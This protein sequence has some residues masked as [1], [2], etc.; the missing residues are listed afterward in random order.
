MGHFDCTPSFGLVRGVW[1]GE[2]YRVVCGEADGGMRMVRCGGGADAFVADA[3]VVFGFVPDHPDLID[4]AR[5]H[6]AHG[7]LSRVVRRAA[8]PAIYRRGMNFRAAHT[9]TSDHPRR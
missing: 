2:G 3:A 7:Y 1:A 8:R 6:G 4:S 5:Q 9:I